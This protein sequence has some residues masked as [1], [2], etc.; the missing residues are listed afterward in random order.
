MNGE[1]AVKE[2]T[3]CGGYNGRGGKLTRF[4]L[5]ATKCKFVM[6]SRVLCQY[7]IVHVDIP[8]ELQTDC[9]FCTYFCI[10]KYN[11]NTL[12]LGRQITSVVSMP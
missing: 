2:C 6:K 7:E 5:C 1:L 3:H 11:T 10:L 4:C 12:W 8:A 9:T